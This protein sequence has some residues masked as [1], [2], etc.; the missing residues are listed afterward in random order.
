MEE[1]IEALKQQIVDLVRRYAKR[2]GGVTFEELEGLL[3]FGQVMEDLKQAK[4]VFYGQAAPQR[5]PEPEL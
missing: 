2:T 1:K 5:Q 3:G 4:A